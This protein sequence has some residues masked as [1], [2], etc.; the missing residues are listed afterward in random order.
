M[1]EKRTVNPVYNKAKANNCYSRPILDILF[2]KRF[3]LFQVPSPK[4]TTL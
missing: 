2:K 4:T 1:L 3:P